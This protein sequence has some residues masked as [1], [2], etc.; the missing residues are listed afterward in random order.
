MGKPPRWKVW[1]GEEMYII[2]GPKAPNTGLVQIS[3]WVLSVWAFR[4]E[5]KGRQPGPRVCEWV[6]AALNHL[7]LRAE[8]P[9][10]RTYSVCSPQVPSH[11]SIQSEQLV[12]SCAE[13][14]DST[15]IQENLIR[16]FYGCWW[17]HRWTVGDIWRQIQM[18]NRFL[19]IVELDQV[20]LFRM[21]K[22]L[23][24]FEWIKHFNF[25]V[26]QYL[27]WFIS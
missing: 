27:K 26:T 24:S 3:P 22:T 10:V 18:S 12:Q 2:D 25:I 16:D 17:T 21:N 11:V 9:R 5:E 4:G 1:L 7:G 6:A 13:Q 8:Y 14:H 15:T 20:H 19:Q 23:E